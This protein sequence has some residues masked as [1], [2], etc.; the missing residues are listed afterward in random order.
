MRNFYV[1]IMANRSR[2]LYVG[3]TNDLERR[4]A[5]HRAGLSNFTAKYDIKKLVYYESAGSPESASAREKQTKRLLRSK[6]VEL[7]ESGNA[8]WDDLSETWFSEQR[9]S[10]LRSE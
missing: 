3:M 8:E 2:T 5:E 7:I 9:D 10:S 4:V 1:Y 6:K